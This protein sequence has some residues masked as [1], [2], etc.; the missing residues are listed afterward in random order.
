LGVVVAVLRLL[1]VT[2]DIVSNRDARF[3]SR[4]WKA[5][6]KAMGTKLQFSNTYRSGRDEP[7]KR[8]NKF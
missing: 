1:Q 5:L 2:K 3:L 7:T 8:L 6:Q 4:L